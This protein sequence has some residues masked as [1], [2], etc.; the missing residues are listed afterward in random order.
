MVR[1]LVQLPRLLLSGFALVLI[2]QIIFHHFYKQEYTTEFKQLQRPSA[3]EFYQLASLGSERLLSY[4]LIL[5]LQLHDNQVGKNIAYAR[6]DYQLLTE[7]FELIYNLNPESDYPAFL[8]SRVYSQ[9]SDEV[10]VRK[11]I[12]LLEWLFEKNPQQ[13]WRRM[14]EACLL[15]KHQLKD[16]D[17]ALKLAEKV[18]DLPANIR[19]PFWARDMRI[20]LLD[21]L[22]EYE[23]AIILIS[24]LLQSNEIKDPDE[25]RFLETRLLKIRQALSENEQINK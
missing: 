18:A 11:M 17:L 4:L 13:H 1:D 6:L 22:N 25:K 9:V 15:A 24:S 20:V 12:A 3:K 2:I 23:S 21:E 10:K 19:L 8:A 14:T 5:K 16:M 7:W